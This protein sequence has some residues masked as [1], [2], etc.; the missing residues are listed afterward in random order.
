MTTFSPLKKEVDLNLLN[1]SSL[2]TIILFSVIVI[3]EL[4]ALTFFQPSQPSP[5][6]SLLLLVK[7]V[8]FDDDG[9]VVVCVKSIFNANHMNEWSAHVYYLLPH[10]MHIYACQQQSIF[11]KGVE[12]SHRDGFGVHSKSG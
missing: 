11:T 1:C 2:I 3:H 10:Y 4:S 5:T 9:C 7:L 8:I 12:E 6:T